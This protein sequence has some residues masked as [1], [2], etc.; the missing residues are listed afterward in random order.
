MEIVA[1]WV[2]T[3]SVA[4]SKK[5][6]VSVIVILI[7]VPELLLN[8]ADA[9]GELQVNEVKV[10]SEE[11]TSSVVFFAPAPAQNE[12]TPGSILSELIPATNIARFEIQPELLSIS[13]T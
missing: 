5:S 9:V 12:A 2:Q 10:I 3:P 1:V 4:S 6:E 11:I 8:T 13:A 7:G